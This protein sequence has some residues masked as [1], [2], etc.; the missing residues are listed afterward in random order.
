MGS[1][2]VKAVSAAAAAAAAA[3]AVAVMEELNPLGR[4]RA[5]SRRASTAT[6]LTPATPQ[7]SAG[8]RQTHYR[9]RKLAGEEQLW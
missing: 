5:I 4:P 7:R 3:E 1:S 9:G 8:G 2:K 6:A